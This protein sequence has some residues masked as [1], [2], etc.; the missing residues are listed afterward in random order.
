MATSK[1]RS[2]LELLIVVVAFFGVW[3]VRATYLYALDAAIPSD[4]LRAV[5][6]NLVKAL[7]W[8]GPAF[9]FAGWL[10]RS[11]PLAYLGLSRWPSPRQWASSFVVLGLFLGA[12]VGVEALSERK[13]LAFAGPS[14]ALT[15]PS[16]LSAFVS[17]LLEEILFRGLLLK[18][19]SRL[20]PDWRANLL[21]SLLFA[22]IHWPFWLSHGGL[23][24]AMLA[25]TGGVFLFSLVAG[26]LYQRSASLWPS[27]LAHVANNGVA[28]LLAI[29]LA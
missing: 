26:W 13:S 25:N 21:T 9:A 10:R 24:G 5:Y 14:L 15:L 1:R 22:G 7:L 18:E 8:V 27:Y 17:P 28:A 16:L 23:T 11:P 6:S 3:S 19:F 4:A 12:V 2:A 20:W 29:A